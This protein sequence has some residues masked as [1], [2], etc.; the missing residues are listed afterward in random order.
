MTGEEGCDEN[1][2]NVRSP[3]GRKLRIWLGTTKSLKFSTIGVKGMSFLFLA[4]GGK[5]ISLDDPIEL[6]ISK[7]I[8]PGARWSPS[9]CISP[10][11]GANRGPG[12]VNV[13]ELLPMHSLTDAQGTPMQSYPGASSSVTGQRALNY[14]VVK[15]VPATS[16]LPQ[17]LSCRKVSDMQACLCG[18]GVFGM[19]WLFGFW[20]Y[21]DLRLERGRGSLLFHLCCQRGQV[22]N[23]QNRK[24]VN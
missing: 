15:L 5:F 8:Q 23:F 2:S 14:T 12:H 1:W 21:F 16:A 7:A 13:T 19:A 10:D 4:G 6:A 17:V 20:P 9:L 3:I 24:K 22:Y 18:Y 11:H